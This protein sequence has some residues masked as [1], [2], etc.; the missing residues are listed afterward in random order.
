M[1]QNI[2]QFEKFNKTIKIG[3]GIL[4]KNP[5]IVTEHD[6]KTKY[7]KLIYIQ[8]ENV[9]YI[10]KLSLLKNENITFANELKKSTY[11]RE[12]LF[13]KICNIIP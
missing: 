13:E 10:T 1:K 2:I 6:L 9:W 8:Y 12:Q 5:D 4:T 7:N 3:I 11:S